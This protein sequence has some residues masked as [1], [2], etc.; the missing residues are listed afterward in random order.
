MLLIKYMSDEISQFGSSRVKPII[1]YQLMMVD[2]FNS[3]IPVA[4]GFGPT[5][6]A[7]EMAWRMGKM[8][9][10]RGGAGAKEEEEKNLVWR[11][12]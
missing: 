1:S 4:L 2:L 7:M 11:S 10:K 8:I 12:M 9:G 5:F 3:F 6:V